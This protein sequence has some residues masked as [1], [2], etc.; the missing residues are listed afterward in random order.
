MY[1]LQWKFSNFDWKGGKVNTR[2]FSPP[3]ICHSGG[4][5][6]WDWGASRCTDDSFWC[7]QSHDHIG[8]SRTQNEAGCDAWEILWRCPV[9]GAVRYFYRSC[10]NTRWCLLARQRIKH[11]RMVALWT[12]GVTLAVICFLMLIHIG[13]EVYYFILTLSR[14]FKMHYSEVIMSAMASQITGVSMVCWAVCSGTAQNKTSRLRV[15]GLC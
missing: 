11:C 8:F 2:L 6:P 4:G 10:A 15:T 3:G 12:I 14:V 9:Y 1:F 7:F 5:W 13:V